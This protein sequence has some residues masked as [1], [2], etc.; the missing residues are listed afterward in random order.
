MKIRLVVFLLYFV[1][2][3]E[4][5]NADIQGE[6]SLYCDSTTNIYLGDN[7]KSLMTV[8]TSQIYIDVKYRDSPD[9]NSIQIYYGGLQDLG[10]GGMRLGI[11]WKKLSKNDPIALFSKVSKREARLKWFGF[12]D[13]SGVKVDV[14][15][16]FS[17]DE[18]NTLERCQ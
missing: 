3:S 10:V 12:V 1:V 15:S 8:L 13:T 14:M 4:S 11:P 2:V 9:K 7:G 5:A 6:W 18:V 17:E 16:D